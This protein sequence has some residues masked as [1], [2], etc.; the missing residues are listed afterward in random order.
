MIDCKWMHD[1]FCCNDACPM[2]CDYCPVT[3]YPGVCRYE[4]RGDENDAR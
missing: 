4:E 2:C 3:D 1:E